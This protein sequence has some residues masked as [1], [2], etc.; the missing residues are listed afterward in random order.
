MKF[1]H[2]RR[3]HVK[4]ILEQRKTVAKTASYSPFR[5]GKKGVYKE[6]ENTEPDRENNRVDVCTRDGAV[7]ADNTR[8][9]RSWNSNDRSIFY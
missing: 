1:A 2:V 3:S 8:N 5:G 7:K 4:T 9:P 6:G